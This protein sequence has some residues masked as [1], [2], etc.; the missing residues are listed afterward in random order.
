MVKVVRAEVH[1]VSRACYNVIRS[2]VESSTRDEYIWNIGVIV[3]K[4]ALFKKP[5]RWALEIYPEEGVVLLRG[6]RGIAFSVE[7]DLPLVR[8]KACDMLFE[9]TDLAKLLP[10]YFTSD[11]PYAEPVSLYDVVRK[12]LAYRDVVVG[13]YYKPVEATATT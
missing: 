1:E 5:G 4:V 9:V 2:F 7:V 11:V 13:E 6:R 12:V 10:I 8:V 3:G